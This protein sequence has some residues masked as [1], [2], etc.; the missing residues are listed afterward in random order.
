MAHD[1]DDT[2]RLNG[3]LGAAGAPGA[4]GGR[5]PRPIIVAGIS[6]GAVAAML[7]G[8][9]LILRPE[10]QPPRIEPSPPVTIPLVPVPSPARDAPN[11]AP[12]AA[13]A[14]AIS[15][16][17]EAEIL[18]NQA[19]R[20]TIFRFAPN[21]RVLVLDFPTLRE[22]GLMLNRVA[23]LVEKN[24][25]PRDRVLT[26]TELDHA[27]RASGDTV[28]TYYYGHDYRAADLAAFFALAD[29][30]HVALGA[31]E[32][33]LRALLAQEAWLAPGATGA[34][35]SVPREGADASVDARFRRTIL[36]HELAHGEYF[37][38][39]VYSSYTHR[40]FHD[41]M[42]EAA[43]QAFRHF[44]AGE[45]YDAA[46]DDL[47]VNETQAYLMHTP[48]ARVFNAAMLG[49]ST[50]A[51]ALLQAEFLLG[52]PPGW[53]RD[54][55][56]ASVIPPAALAHRQGGQKPSRPRQRGAIGTAVTRASTRAPLRLAV[57]K[58]V[59]KSRK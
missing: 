25:Q 32:E 48:D 29:R 56:N 53:L 44:L 51:L 47:V 19:T 3:G 59:R 52:M 57:S 55:T 54:C 11:A 43:R 39:P 31:E 28:E 23:A 15:N 20:L 1:H 7:I 35:I 6:A 27:I 16:A 49:I 17:T 41:T 37:T 33:R 9:W 4:S 14:F 8:A 42:D 22:Q 46:I 34:L 24:G 58:A 2:V 10:L 26:D 5:W 12:P 40:F 13:A 18:A 50:H 21:P 30:D 45:D 36:H 38:N